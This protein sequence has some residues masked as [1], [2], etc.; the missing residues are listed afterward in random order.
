[1]G[2]YQSYFWSFYFG[3]KYFGSRF[4]YVSILISWFERGE[5]KSLKSDEEKK[6]FPIDQDSDNEKS[7]F[8]C[9]LALF[10][11]RSSVKIFF[12]HYLT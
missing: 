10:N 11:E 1:M 12:V 6:K 4:Y 5:K 8:W 9:Q 3:V 2:F 7:R